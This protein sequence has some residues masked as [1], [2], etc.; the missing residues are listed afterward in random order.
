MDGDFVVFVLGAFLILFAGI[1]KIIAK[2]MDAIDKKKS[3]IEKEKN[4]RIAEYETLIKETNQQKAELDKKL[5]TANEYSNKL[6]INARA[7]SDNIT[8]EAEQKVQKA[9]N[10]SKNAIARVEEYI[11]KKSE[12][13]PHLAAIRADLLTQHY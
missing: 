3:L 5:E 8:K 6:I 7:F 10:Y 4:S 12:I 11:S 13:Y 1:I 9:D 2:I